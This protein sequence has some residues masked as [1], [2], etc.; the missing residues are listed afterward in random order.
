[1]SITAKIALVALV[2]AAPAVATDFTATGTFSDGTT[3][4]VRIATGDVDGDGVSDD[5]V[6]KLVCSGGTISSASL[7]APRD[8]ATGQ[9]SGRRMHKP[10]VFTKQLDV[11]SKVA[12]PMKGTYDLKS[13]TKRGKPGTASWDLATNKGGRS[14]KTMAMDDWSEIT[15]TKLD[16]VCAAGAMSSLVSNPAF[17]NSGMSGTM[18][19]AERT[20]GG[21]LPAVKK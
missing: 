11:S 17:Q 6:I 3:R 15:V 18:P 8:V 4:Y 9:A 21:A 5:G 14:N 16:Q 12:T 19:S 13:G 2:M 10:F 20:E 7:Y 1:M